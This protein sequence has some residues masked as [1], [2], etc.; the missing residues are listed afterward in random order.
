MTNLNTESL[1]EFHGTRKKGFRAVMLIW[2]LSGH[3]VAEPP[4]S[5]VG[6]RCSGLAPSRWNIRP[7]SGPVSHT[8]HFRDRTARGVA[9]SSGLGSPH[10][11]NLSAKTGG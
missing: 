5:P 1:P 8:R 9:I 3:A 2:S 4:A 7:G 6:T 10:D 11:E